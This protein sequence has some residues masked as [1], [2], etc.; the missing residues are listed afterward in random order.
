[1]VE[2]LLKGAVGRR[3]YG[4]KRLVRNQARRGGAGLRVENG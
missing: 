3:E 1:M 4:S 2:N